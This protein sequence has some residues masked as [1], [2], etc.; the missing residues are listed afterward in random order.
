MKNAMLSGVRGVRTRFKLAV[1]GVASLLVGAVALGGPPT[2]DAIPD[3]VDHASIVTSWIGA[4]AGV[5]ILI[6][7]VVMAFRL[8]NKLMQRTTRAI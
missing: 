8:V 3:T 4:A 7:G 5:L 1:A 6:F 2:L